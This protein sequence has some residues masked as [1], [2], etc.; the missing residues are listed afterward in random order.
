MATETL[1][2]FRS[3]VIRIGESNNQLVFFIAGKLIGLPFFCLFFSVY[4]SFFQDDGA[5]GAV[6]D[7]FV[8]AS[9]LQSI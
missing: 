6:C 4:L 5:I 3:S 2:C 1:Y 8:P 7:C 9:H